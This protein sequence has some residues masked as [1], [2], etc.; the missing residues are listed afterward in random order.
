MTQ[1]VACPD[2]S[3]SKNYQIYIKPEASLDSRIH[4]VLQAAFIDIGIT[5]TT[6][7]N[8]DSQIAISCIQASSNFPE[9]PHQLRFAKLSLQCRAIYGESA[10]GAASMSSEGGGITLDQAKEHAVEA[11]LIEIRNSLITKFQGA[12]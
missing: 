8:A 6:N 11:M 4:A 12:S 5:P 1:P 9:V 7:P 2:L 10:F 3:A